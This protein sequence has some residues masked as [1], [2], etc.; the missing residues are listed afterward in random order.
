VLAAIDAGSNTLRLLIGNV[1]DGRVIPEQYLRCI[2]RLAGDFSPEKG[3]S[4]LAMERTLSALCDFA[5][6][7]EAKGV[8]RL[9]AV[10]TA[11]FRMAANGRAF[12][13]QIQQQSGVFLEIITGEQEAALMAAGV[14]STLGSTNQPCLIF[15]IGG[16]STE[17][18]LVRGGKVHWSCS[19]PLGVVRITE[20]RQAGNI[21]PTLIQDVLVTAFPQL[22]A[23]CAEAAI[24][25]HDLVLIGTAGTVTTLAALDMAMDDYDWRR[26][27]GYRICLSR[28]EYW[29]SYLGPLAPGERESLAG[30]EAGR[31]DLIIAGIDIILAI[32]LMLG[33]EELLVSD[34]GILEGLLLSLSAPKVQATAD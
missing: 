24:K 22:A 6:T 17:L 31:G 2:T 8:H 26:V 28:V 32:M 21:R 3:L 20:G 14:L 5:K 13:R 23:T 33:T 7:C 30:L 4:P 18:V 16:G 27:N 25:I 11:A 29:Q 10:G 12:A 15:D 34:F 1:S 9:A 19:L